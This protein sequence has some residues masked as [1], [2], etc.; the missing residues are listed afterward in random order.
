MLQLV[1]HQ[2]VAVATETFQGNGRA[3]HMAA[4]ALQLAPIAGLGQATAALSEK[5]SR[6]A[7]NGFA[8]SRPGPSSAAPGRGAGEAGTVRRA[9]GRHGLP[10]TK[11]Q[12]P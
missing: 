2:A 11:F 7:V 8:G 9:G 3:R 6:A 10:G 4:Q 1:D 12:C 5:P